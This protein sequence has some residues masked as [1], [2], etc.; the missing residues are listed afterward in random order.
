MVLNQDTSA[1]IAAKAMRENGIG[2]I[3]VKD[4]KGGLIGIVTDR[5]FACRWGADYNGADV[6]I[7]RLMTPEILKADEGAGMNDIISLMENHGLR[8]IPIVTRAPNGAERVI[9]LVTLDDLIASGEVAPSR[10][11]RIVR[12]QIGRRMSQRQH[13]PTLRSVQSEAHSRQSLDRFYTSFAQVTG[14]KSSLVPQMTH[15]LLSVLLMRVTATAAE[16]FLA[17]LPKLLQSSLRGLPPGPDRHVSPG[18]VMADLSQY[19]GIAQEQAE[20]VL[21]RFL[22]GLKDVIDPHLVEHLRAHL[23]LEFQTL[24]EPMKSKQERV[25]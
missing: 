2:C 11:A 17:Q 12:T 3:L 4:G 7:S 24:F 20:P 10:L 16:H 13:R 14:V 15:Y 9:G 5:D 18:Y 25:A 23:P 1:Q 22:S 6:A 19:Y 8:R 21:R